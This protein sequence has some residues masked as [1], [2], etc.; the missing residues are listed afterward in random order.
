MLISCCNDFALVYLLSPAAGGSK[1][2]GN[3]LTQAL[4]NLP[5][6][7]FATG[8]YTNMQRIACFCWKSLQYGI[9]GFS[10]GVAGSAAVNSMT[11]LRELTDAK[12]EPPSEAPSAI[13]TGL[14]WL[15]FMGISSNV[16]YNLIAF[17]EQFLYRRHPG[18]LSK[19]GSIALRLVNNFAAAYLWVDLAD[20]I[21][22]QQ[23]RRSLREER[24][25]RE[26]RAARAKWLWWQRKKPEPRPWPWRLL[27]PVL[28][29]VD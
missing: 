28:P 8:L 27:Q 14:G 22:V 5:P 1:V 11:D 12:F 17:A 21:G 15:Y 13:L 29:G 18:S 26:R 25:R 6:H 24:R 2:A 16:R 23:P 9:I 4:Q 7:V 20:E 10:M 3:A 19:M